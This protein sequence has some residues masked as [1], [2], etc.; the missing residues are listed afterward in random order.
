MKNI[1]VTNITIYCVD[2]KYESTLI[3]ILD[4]VKEK[5]LESLDERRIL[6][7]LLDKEY[8][9]RKEEIDNLTIDS[10]VNKAMTE[11]CINV[12][13]KQIASDQRQELNEELKQIRDDIT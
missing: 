11:F 1:E 5:L 9:N 10:L 12:R 7:G 4:I 2:Q 3:T 13:R 6:E 8:R